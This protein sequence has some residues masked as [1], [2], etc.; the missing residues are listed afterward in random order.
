MTQDL[1]L[2]EIQTLVELKAAITRFANG[3][4]EALRMAEAEIGRTSEWLHERIG[5]WQHELERARS[6]LAAARAALERCLQSGYY[7][8]DGHYYAP[9]CSAEEKAIEHAEMRLR[10]CKENLR[11]AQAWR[12]RLEQAVD[13]YHRKVRRLNELSAAHSDM[14]KAQL[15]QLRAKYEAVQEAANMVGFAGEMG[16]AGFVSSVVLGVKGLK[17]VTGRTDQLLGQGA[18]GLVRHLLEEE[19]ACNQVPFDKPKKGTGFDG[20]LRTPNG[21]LVILE[22]KYS[23]DGKL[24]LDYGYG[25]RETSAGWVA[26]VAQQMSDPKSGLYSETNARIG[27]QIFDTG[28]EEVPVLAVVINPNTGQADI[29]LRTGPDASSG[30]WMPFSGEFF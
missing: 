7:D 19:L 8:R 13:E 30:D 9:N 27:Q 3:T 10:E 16:I 21:Q 4:Q 24:K 15:D 29:Y 12:N 22:S 18:E 6:E 20:I 1:D 11:K 26:A 28:P 14:A 5:H 17:L 2:R 25:Y 23:S